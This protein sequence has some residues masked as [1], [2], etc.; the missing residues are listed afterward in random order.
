MQDSARKAHL[1]TQAGARGSSALFAFLI[2]QLALLVGYAG[3]VWGT[4]FAASGSWKIALL[5]AAVLCLGFGA[6]AL[7][8]HRLQERE[9]DVLRTEYEVLR[10]RADAL[11]E[12]VDRF[13]RSRS[14]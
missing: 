3:G 4:Q 8:F 5:S 1:E 9:D 13:E 12:E 10:A 14:G 2:L 11:V 7:I 6:S